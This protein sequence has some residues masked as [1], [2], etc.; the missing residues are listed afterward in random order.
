MD[1]PIVEYD[2]KRKIV[3]LTCREWPHVSDQFVSMKYDEYESWLK[4]ELK[5]LVK[6]RDVP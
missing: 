1:K 5:A 6:V 2:I 3:E 4:D